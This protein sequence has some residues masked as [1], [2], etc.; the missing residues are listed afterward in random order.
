VGAGTVTVTVDGGCAVGV[1]GPGRLAI[2]VRVDGLVIGLLLVVTVVLVGGAWDVG[3]P[4][5]RDAAIANIAMP[6]DRAA[7][8]SPTT[9]NQPARRWGSTH[10]FPA[11]Q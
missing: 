9:M 7:K 4:F 10:S 8:A 11:M 2:D 5:S 6:M 1:G 3:P